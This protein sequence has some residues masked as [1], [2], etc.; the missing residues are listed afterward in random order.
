MLSIRMPAKNPELL[1]YEPEEVIGED[2][3]QFDTPG[4]ND[5]P[6]DSF[7]GYSGEPTAL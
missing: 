4:G 1:G 7:P 3:F 5:T 2:A 6:E